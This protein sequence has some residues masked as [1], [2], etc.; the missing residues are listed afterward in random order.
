MYDC[1]IIGA[2]IAGM[3]AS[4]YLK[5]ANKKVLIIE[6]ETIGGQIASSPLVSNYPGFINIS[7]PELV[8]NIYDQVVHLDIPLEIEEVQ[9]IVDGKIKKVITDYNTYET[10]TII[11]ATGAKYRRLNLPNEDNLIGNGIHFCVT[12]DGAF[13]KNKTVAVIGGGNT[14]LINALALSD[15]CSKVY[16]I[17]NL[18]ELTGEIVLQEKI[19]E[20]DNIEVLTNSTVKELIGEENLEYI[21]IEKDKTLEKL[22]LDGM[23]ISIGLVPQNEIFKDIIKLDKNNYINSN[24]CKTN[25]DGIFVSGD[26]RTKEY[27][28]LTTAS[29]DGTISALH[30][31][32]YLNR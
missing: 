7:G 26:C 23:F 17:Q 16:L 3:T 13:Y 30:V 8:S 10:K 14:A 19:K 5:R 25:I 31:I 11:I 28:Q 1:I 15:I 22:K 9:S 18:K 2:G 27:R 32:D 20:K 4:I 12:C 21:I 24:D 6:K 29:S